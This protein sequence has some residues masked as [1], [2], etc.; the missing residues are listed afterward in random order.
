MKNA[1]ARLHDLFPRYLENRL[2]REEYEEW[3][4]LLSTAD[5]AVQEELE[6]LWE[7]SGSF[8]PVI[9]AEAWEDKM[10]QR[11]QPAPA[12]VFRQVK[13]LPRWRTTK[14]WAAAAVLLVCGTLYF[15]GE[16][17]LPAGKRMQVMLQADLPPGGNRAVLT[18]GNGSTIVLDSAHNGPL[19]QQGAAQIL[20]PGSNSISYTSNNH[21]QE[22]VYNTLT[23]PR[24]G[25]Y[26]VALS[27]GTRVWLNAAS[28]IRFPATFTGKE[29]RVEITGEAYFEVAPDAA[30][31]FKV[32]VNDMEVMVLGTHFNVMAYEEESMI[33]TTLLEGAVKVSRQDKSVVLQPGQQA[34]AGARDA[35]RLASGV[36]VNEVMA[37]KNGL[38]WF[39]NA[40]VH[41]VMRQVARWYNVD[42]EVRGDI[43][44]HFT[45][46]I[47][48]NVQVSR[49]FEI[50]QE[51]GSMHYMITKDKII[52]S[53]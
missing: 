22:L 12:P 50:L 27:D 2:T 28:S 46:S 37:W 53:P 39:E 35:I 38:F 34:Q 4:L 10:A 13:P 3:L 16:R 40:D 8:R 19:A 23:T 14:W 25:Q 31:V 47:P 30:R 44:L 29:R 41:S 17:P 11:M 7:Q 15:Y 45:G 6:L 36:D 51:A 52:V 32:T 5:A 33:R 9:T 49:V 20:K 43:A 48:R 1:V 24:G 42:V 18:L 26:S 21:T